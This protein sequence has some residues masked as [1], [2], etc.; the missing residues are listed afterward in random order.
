MDATD[1]DYTLLN[2]HATVLFDTAKAQGDREGYDRGSTEAAARHADSTLT[3][4]S[5]FLALSSDALASA[6]AGRVQQAGRLARQM[7]GQTPQL[8]QEETLR[9]IGA[10]SDTLDIG[11]AGITAER[12]RE[13]LL[14]IREARV[15]LRRRYAFLG[16]LR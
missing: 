14:A 16:E 4:A 15:S 9:A 10:L 8:A 7:L 6:D 11:R 12:I 2:E 1:F 13:A 3:A 5:A